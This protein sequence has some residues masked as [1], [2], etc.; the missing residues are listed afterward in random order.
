MRA[1]AKLLITNKPFSLRAYFSVKTRRVIDYMQMEPFK[2]SAIIYKIRS[3]Y[4]PFY[5]SV[6]HKLS[7]CTHEYAQRQ[8]RVLHVSAQRRNWLTNTVQNELFS[9]WNFRTFAALRLLNDWFFFL[10]RVP[11]FVLFSTA[12]SLLDSKQS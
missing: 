6:T 4:G 3:N 9:K 5:E 11:G 1:Y 12:D 8:S 10:L 2:C 7:D